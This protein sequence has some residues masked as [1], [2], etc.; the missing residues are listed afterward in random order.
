MDHIRHTL[1][2]KSLHW[3]KVNERIEYKLLSHK[4]LTTAQPS[5]LHNLISLHL[6][7]VPTPRLLSLFFARQPS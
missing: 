5:Y 4:V 2:L 7:A 1:I 6:L 3:L